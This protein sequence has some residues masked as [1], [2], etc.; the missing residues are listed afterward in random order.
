MKPN[1]I[2]KTREEL[3]QAVRD[4]GHPFRAKQRHG[5]GYWQGVTILTR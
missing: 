2:G 4:L 1:L 3:T 5:T